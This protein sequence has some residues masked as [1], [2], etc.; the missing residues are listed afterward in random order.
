MTS[1]EN[2]LGR[3]NQAPA[4]GTSRVAAGRAGSSAINPEGWATI[5]WHSSQ[6]KNT[7]D[8][9]NHTH[10]GSW[11]PLLTLVTLQK[12]TRERLAAVQDW[13]HTV[14]PYTQRLQ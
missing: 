8:G 4:A 5:P 14:Y 9:D 10:L 1:K 6:Y 2:G 11:L 3:Y 12:E 7:G 13:P